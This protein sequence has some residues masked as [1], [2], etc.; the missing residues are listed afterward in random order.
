MKEIQSGGV[1]MEN[2]MLIIIAFSIFV[3]VFVL[4]FIL[5]KEFFAPFIGK[6]TYDFCGKVREKIW[7]IRI[8]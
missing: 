4:I 1:G 5:I 7:K 3:E 6:C 8:M 2:L